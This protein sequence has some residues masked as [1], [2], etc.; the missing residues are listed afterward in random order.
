MSA[1]GEIISRPCYKYKEIAPSKSCSV[2]PGRDLIAKLFELR[3]QLYIGTQ[4]IRQYRARTMEPTRYIRTTI[5]KFLRCRDSGEK[6]TDEHQ[7][8]F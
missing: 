5:W 7:R 2:L 4:V 6:I 3:M 8:H 1:V